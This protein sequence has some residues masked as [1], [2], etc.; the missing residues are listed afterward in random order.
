MCLTICAFRSNCFFFRL[1]LSV[2]NIESSHSLVVLLRSIFLCP[3]LFYVLVRSR[4][5]FYSRDLCHSLAMQV[6]CDF[7]F[8]HYSLPKCF[9]NREQ[10][11]KNQRKEPKSKKKRVTVIQGEASYETS[12][13][14][15]QS[16]QLHNSR[17]NLI[18]G[19]SLSLSLSLRLS[20]TKSLY[21]PSMKPLLSS[22]IDH[23]TLK[24]EKERETLCSCESIHI[25]CTTCPSPFTQTR[26][27][28]VILDTF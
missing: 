17:S 16:A 20:H 18:L 3:V 11:I 7:L 5:Y 28:K 13:P 15:I 25:E 1:F 9:Q 22:P 6:K 24:R 2:C 8:I 27:E 10:E 19:L 21:P 23:V 4:S 26:S 14:V 12:E